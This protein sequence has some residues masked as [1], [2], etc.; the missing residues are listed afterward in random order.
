MELFSSRKSMPHK[1]VGLFSALLYSPVNKL[2][3]Q[4]PHTFFNKTLTGF[5][6]LSTINNS[7]YP[8]KQ[9]TPLD[10]IRYKYL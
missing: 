2:H 5:Y 7:D 1:T 8:K 4:V 3:L 10:H 6:R 9:N